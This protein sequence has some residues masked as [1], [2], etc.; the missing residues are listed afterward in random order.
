M[1]ELAISESPHGTELAVSDFGGP[2]EDS[3]LPP[4][5]SLHPSHS[6]PYARRGIGGEFECCRNRLS[7]NPADELRRSFA[8]DHLLPGW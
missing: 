4:E 3:L 8:D 7:K 1:A 2:M 6:W 5:D